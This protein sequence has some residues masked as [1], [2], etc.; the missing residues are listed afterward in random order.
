MKI[1]QIVPGVGN[2]STCENC[3]RDA[4]LMK[5][6]DKRGH[7]VVVVP[8][9]LPFRPDGQDPAGD[10]PIFFGGINVYLQQKSVIF[11]KSPRW[12]DR[13]FDK[14]KLLEWALRKFQ[15]VDAK[16]LGQTTVS[17]LKGMD[18]FQAKEFERLSKWL[19]NEENRPDVVC[20]S[21]ALLAGLAGPIKRVIGRPIVCLLQDEDK[22][23][24]D[25]GEPYSQQGWEVLCERVR[26]IDIFIAVSQ[27]DADVMK[28][29]VKIGQDK[30]HVVCGDS[31][32]GV[33]R[34][35][36]ERAAGEIA[37]IF[38]KTTE[39]FSEGNDA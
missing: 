8:L 16:F 36:I 3:L 5:A 37:G 19:S 10:M 24:D 39:N 15:M 35:E 32:A 22:F 13:M 9:Y 23:L 6:F 29:R 17:M 27:R 12:L 21:N 4:A 2:T 30:M 7:E 34:S 1:A 38:I 20:I 18:G 31:K 11:R 25:L 14:P 28:K 33:N 26:D